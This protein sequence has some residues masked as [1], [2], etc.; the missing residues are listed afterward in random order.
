MFVYLAL[1]VF[2]IGIILLMSYKPIHYREYMSPIQE[3]MSP[4]LLGTTCGLGG[5]CSN[6]N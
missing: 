6:N 1:I 2:C 4:R 5:S 3:Y